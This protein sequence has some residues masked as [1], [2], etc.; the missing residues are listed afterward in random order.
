MIVWDAGLYLRQL[1]RVLK[2]EDIRKPISTAV[3][4]TAIVWMVY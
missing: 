3:D 4:S 1:V 2:D